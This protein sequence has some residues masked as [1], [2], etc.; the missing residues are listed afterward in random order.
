MSSRY[1]S[2]CPICRNPYSHFPGICQ[3]LHFLLLK[4]YPITYKKREDQILE[5]EKSVG[6]FSPEFNGHEG[7]A[8][9]DGEYNYLRSPAHSSPCSDSPSTSKEKLSI[10]SAPV[11]SLYNCTIQSKENSDG[12]LSQMKP[13]SGEEKDQVSVADLLCTACKKLP[14]RPVVL[15]CGHVYCQTCVIVHADEMLRC[16]VCRCLHPRGCPKVC[17]TLDQFLVAKFP[18]EYALRKDAV[19]LKQLSS[20]QERATTCSMEAGKLDFSPIQLPSRDYAPF[21]V[22]PSA[23]RHIGVGCD[24]CGMCP[25]VGDR[26]KCKDCT[27]KIGFDLCGDCYNTR[28]KLPGRF[29]QRHTPEHKFE[30]VKCDITRRLRLMTDRLENG[31]TTSFVIFD[32][33]FENLEN[34]AVPLA[35]SGDSEDSASNYMA[36]LFPDND[37]MED[38]DDIVFS[39]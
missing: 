34:G 17:L 21:S 25:I 24:A 19:Q 36:T 2:H 14:L 3:T 37:S 39:D 35:L 6:Y 33:A 20:K 1:E 10:P 7:E 16:Q 8:Q 23:Y 5:E 27:E 29:N 13:V 28:P 32:D 18:K 12:D 22:E 9:A 26:Y 38:Q 4:L 15:N 31:F 11:E 30:L